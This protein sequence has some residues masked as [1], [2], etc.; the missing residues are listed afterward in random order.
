[1]VPAA[2]FSKHWDRVFKGACCIVKIRTMKCSICSVFFVQNSLKLNELLWRCLC[3]A[4]GTVAS[5]ASCI[6]LHK[7]AERVAVA[8]MEK[9][10]L[11]VGDHVALVYP[12]GKATQTAKVEVRHHKKTNNFCHGRAFKHPFNIVV[13]GGDLMF[14]GRDLLFVVFLLSFFS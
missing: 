4:Q 1:M 9:G 10:R 11:N 2:G 7:R 5:T 8:L 3:S 12:P 13:Y 14:Q 6:Q